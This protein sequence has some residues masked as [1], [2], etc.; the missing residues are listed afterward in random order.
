M[1]IFYVGCK[2]ITCMK[3]VHGM[4]KLIHMQL[5]WPHNAK[6][7]TLKFTIITASEENSA[8]HILSLSMNLPLLHSLSSIKAWERI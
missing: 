2:E 1:P 5:F 6:R 8:S 3:Y 7:N 4:N